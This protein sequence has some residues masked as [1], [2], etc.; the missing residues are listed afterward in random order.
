MEHQGHGMSSSEPAFL[1]TNWGWQTFH[2]LAPMSL[3]GGGEPC[4]KD[5]AAMLELSGKGPWDRLAM[6]AMGV[7]GRVVA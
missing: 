5:S 2:W 7:G 3:S 6:S 4:A 1:P